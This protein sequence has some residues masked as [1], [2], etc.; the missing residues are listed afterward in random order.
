MKTLFLNADAVFFD[1][2]G[3]IADSHHVKTHAFAALYA[4]EH[5]HIVSDVI[6]YHEANGGISR[7]RKFEHYE[8]QL[9]GRDPT[10]ERMTV[11]SDR[12]ATAVVDAV[13]ASPEVPGAGALLQAL[14]ARATPCH[15]ASGTPEEE[16]KEIVARRKLADYFH[17]V[18][19]SPAEKP[20][21][22]ACVSKERGHDVARCVMIGDAM[23]DYKA[24][25]AVG[26]P[27]VGVVQRGAISPFPEGTA[28]VA[29]FWALSEEIR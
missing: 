16:L 21:I 13:V 14:K 15:V 19:G 23:S 25:R 28:V 7:Y 6:A 24:A 10:P 26:M 1:F 9:L 20:D 4:D 3:V 8:R 11:L 17:A 27:F 22:L 5:P 18:R 2:D 29:N 12:F